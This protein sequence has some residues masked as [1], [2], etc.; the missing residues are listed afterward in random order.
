MWGLYR[1]YLKNMMLTVKKLIAHSKVH[2]GVLISN[3]SAVSI[4][5]VKP[6]GGKDPRGYYKSIAGTARTNKP[7]KVT[8]KFEIRLYYPKRRKPDEQYVPVEA[9]EK[10]KPYIGPEEAPPFNLDTA[11]WVTCSCEYFMYHCEV[12]DAQHD[13]SSIKYSNGKFPSETNPSGV[14]HLCKHL[15]SAF[16]KGA[17]IKK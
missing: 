3:A 9:R 12:A 8:K 4:A 2:R 13:N 10:T 15:I 6:R 16:R 5:F 1:L 17:L 7:G 14:A 11:A